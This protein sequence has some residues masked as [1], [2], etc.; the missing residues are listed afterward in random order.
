[1][2]I[3]FPFKK[4]KSVCNTKQVV[5]EVDGED[6]RLSDIVGTTDISLTGLKELEF[7]YDKNIYEFIQDKLYNLE[8]LKEQ[9]AGTFAGIK[10]NT[11]RL[12]IG[13]VYYEPGLDGNVGKYRVINYTTAGR[14]NWLV[15]DWE[16][17]AKVSRRERRISQT[18]WRKEISGDAW[19]DIWLY[20]GPQTDA[21]TFQI[22]YGLDGIFYQIPTGY[23]LDTSTTKYQTWKTDVLNSYKL[24]I[25]IVKTNGS[26][27]VH[28]DLSAA[29]GF[30]FPTDTQSGIYV[31]LIDFIV[32]NEA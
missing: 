17:D 7:L 31:P 13:S 15:L 22:G 5:H 12:D 16:L 24:N 32:P 28:I 19:R 20:T 6:K 4:I 18:E 21:S 2:K 23:H 8:F 1:M 30:T 29:E 9:I 27:T 10:S 26:D 14:N 11:I 25:D 3:K